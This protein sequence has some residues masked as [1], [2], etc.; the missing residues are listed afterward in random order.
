[1]N[2]KTKLKNLNIKE[3][4]ELLMLKEELRLRQIQDSPLEFAKQIFIP[5]VPVNDLEDCDKFYADKITPAKHH[6]IILNT[7]GDLIKGKLLDENKKPIKSCII[8]A[9]PGSAKSTYASLVIPTWYM[10]KYPNKNLIMTTYGADLAN[11]FGRKC[12]QICGSKEFR[13]IFN[14]GLVHGNKAADDWSITNSSTYM[15]GGIRSG[16]TGNRADGVVID[17]PFSGRE[18]AESEAIRKKTKLAYKDDVLTRIKP[19]GWKLIINTRWHEE[20]LCG[21]ILP[22]DYQGGSGIYTAKDGEKWY[23]LNFQAECQTDTDPLNR[24]IGEFLWLDWFNLEWWQQ[25]KR[26]KAGY[27]WSSLYQGVPTPAEGVFFKREWFKRYNIGQ[28]PQRLNK[29][30]AGDYAVTS[31]AG[32]FTEIGCA[33]FDINNDLWFLDWWSGQETADIWLSHL[34]RLVKKNDPIVS[35]AEGGIIRRSIEPFLKKEMQ[36][37]D[38]WFRQEW[39]TSNKDK[40]A[41]ARA[42]QGLVSQGKVWI[43][44]CPWGEELI[45]QLIR[46][47]FGKFDDKVDVCGLI[48]RILDQ[49]FAPSVQQLEDKLKTLDYELNEDSDNDWMIN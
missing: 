16:I 14:Q 24:E 1:M 23:V 9:P 3:L 11:K 38:T 47:P 34:V 19:N 45:D 4:Q 17:D 26:N 15:C 43:P 32:D 2:L 25:T 27:S 10:G 22:A 29:Y 7:V 37:Q 6:E 39:I 44:N 48:G 31:K 13:E 35:V 8:L 21:D 41:N 49:T 36:N 18:G 33:G 5:S 12:R 28:E 30:I 42:F 46:F 20:D 40:T